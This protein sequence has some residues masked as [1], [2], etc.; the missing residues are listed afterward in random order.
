MRP[1][2]LI[3]VGRVTP[4][5][6]SAIDVL[7]LEDIG[8]LFGRQSILHSLLQKWLPLPRACLRLRVCQAFLSRSELAEVYYF[9]S[10]WCFQDWLWLAHDNMPGKRVSHLSYLA[11]LAEREPSLRCGNLFVEHPWQLCLLLCF[12]FLTRQKDYPLLKST[13]RRKDSESR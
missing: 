13:P 7:I 4:T 2:H 9:L 6:G 12:I 5:A 11:R 3:C 1:P 10:H 8:L